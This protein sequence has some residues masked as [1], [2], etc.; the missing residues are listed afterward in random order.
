MVNAK[1]VLISIV[2][3][4]VSVKKKTADLERNS[5]LMEHVQIASYILE[6]LKMV[7]SVSQPNVLLCKSN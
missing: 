1:N 2:P 3:K 6:H 5:T 4:M 7:S